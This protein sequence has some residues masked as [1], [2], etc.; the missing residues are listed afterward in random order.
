MQQLVQDLSRSAWS[1]GVLASA[2]RSGVTGA[3]TGGKSPEVIASELG[4]SL[5]SVSTMLEVLGE[6][7]LVR[8]D[9]ERF[10]RSPALDAMETSG[11]TRFLAANLQSTL[12]QV[13]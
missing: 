2:I 9:G 4:L 1:A 3:L 10:V 7:G 8:R 12:G 6:L 13:H 11:Q 5:P